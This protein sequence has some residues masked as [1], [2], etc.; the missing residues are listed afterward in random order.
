MPVKSAKLMPSGAPETL[1]GSSVADVLNSSWSAEN[2][3]KTCRRCQ[4]GLSSRK[5]APEKARCFEGRDRTGP[6]CIHLLPGLAA[7]YS[8]KATE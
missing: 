3:G 6:S 4:L 2:T 8:A 5:A 7:N 1:A